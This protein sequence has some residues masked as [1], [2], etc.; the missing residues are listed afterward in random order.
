MTEPGLKLVNPTYSIISYPAK[1]L[2][3]NYTALVYSK[4]LRTLRFGNPIF[5][6]IDSDAFYHNY[7]KFIENLMKKPDSI[8]RLAVLTEDQDVVLGFSVSREDVLDYV[9]VHK[10]NRELGIAKKLIPQNTT[11]FT[12]ITLTALQI[13]RHKEKYQYLKYNPF[14]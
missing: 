6:N 12:H 4:W 11:T 13:W 7:H 5:K 3:K 14:A 10:D 2:P 9:H 1:D 8:V